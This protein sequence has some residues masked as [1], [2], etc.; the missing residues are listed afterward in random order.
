MRLSLCC[1]FQWDND[2]P[3]LASLL[4]LQSDKEMCFTKTLDNNGNDLARGWKN[5][6]RQVTCF[7]TTDMTNL[8]KYALK[9]RIRK[10]PKEELRE[11]VLGR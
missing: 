2:L 6:Y 3:F 7:L 5:S 11:R 1:P 4:T 9:Y 10:M 8:R